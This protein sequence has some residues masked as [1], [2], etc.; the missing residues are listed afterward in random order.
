MLVLLL[1]V[2]NWLLVLMLV[3][4]LIVVWMLTD[5]VLISADGRANVVLIGVLAVAIVMYQSP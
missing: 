5:V 2:L 3:V 1:A 4:L